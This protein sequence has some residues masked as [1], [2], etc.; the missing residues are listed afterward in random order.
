LTGEEVEL[1]TE[2]FDDLCRIH[3]YDWLEQLPRC[4]RWDYRRSAY[5]AMGRRLGDAATAE[6]E[7]IYA[8]ER[9]ELAV[10]PSSGLAPA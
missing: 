8:G 9:H 3:F 5:Q 6:F 4:T 10:P 7:R 2:D 1:P